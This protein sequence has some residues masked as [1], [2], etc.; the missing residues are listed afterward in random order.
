MR[1]CVIPARGGSKRIPRKNIKVLWKTYDY[2]VNQSGDQQLVLRPNN[3]VD[4]L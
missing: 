2:M 4:G 3:R 1:L